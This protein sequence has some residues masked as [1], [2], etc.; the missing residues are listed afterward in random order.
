MA[1]LDLSFERAC[2]VC[3]QMQVG[4]EVY[5]PALASLLPIGGLVG[6]V[7][8]GLLADKLSRMGATSWLTS[9]APLVACTIPLVLLLIFFCTHRTAPL[10]G[11]SCL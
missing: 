5:A 7:G 9:G 4:P 11:I 8:G 2:L 6:G 1:A 10:P 3:L